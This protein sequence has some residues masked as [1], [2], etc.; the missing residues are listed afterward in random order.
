MTRRARDIVGAWTAFA[1]AAR[2]GAVAAGHPQERAASR[3]SLGVSI[4]ESRSLGPRIP[5]TELVRIGAADGPPHATF[6]RIRD[7]RFSAGGD[8]VV[9]D[10]GDGVVKVFDRTGTPRAMFGRV[11]EGPAEFRTPGAWKS[12]ATRSWSSTSAW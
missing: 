11:G 4:T 9:L 10:A 8:L 6:H 7:A 1:I 3:D 5:A 2:A 12:A